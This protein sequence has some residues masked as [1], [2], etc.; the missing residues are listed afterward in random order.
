[1]CAGVESGRSPLAIDF[2]TVG[3]V[4][5]NNTFF[6]SLIINGVEQK[7][8]LIGV[9][10][11]IKSNKFLSKVILRGTNADCPGDIG[12]IL[13]LNDSHQLQILDFSNSIFTSTA[14]VSLAKALR[15][16]RH[17]LRVLNFAYCQLSPRSITALVHA[18]RGNWGL[19]LA[20]E[21]LDLSGNKADV[22]SYT[23][24]LEFLTL[25]KENCCLKRLGLAGLGISCSSTR[26]ALFPALKAL[27]SLECTLTTRQ[28][29]LISSYSFI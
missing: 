19:S 23:L 3:Q 6:Q 20:I 8:A 2:E 1:M 4:L 26:N 13:A 14:I 15:N 22:E 5:A 16:F 17:R 21:E 18:F 24:L 7:D 10:T 27:P 28:N 25:M 29:H 12:D 9:A 11:A